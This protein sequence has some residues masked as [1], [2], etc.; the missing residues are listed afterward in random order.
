MKNPIY[1]ARHLRGLSL[2]IMQDGHGVCRLIDPVLEPS[3]ASI[4]V[5]LD[6]DGK[7]SVT[8][9]AE[10]LSVSHVHMQKIFRSMLSAGVV[11]SQVDPND[12]R[13]TFY[14]LTPSGQKLLPKVHIINGA[15]AKVISDL[16]DETGHD[17][18][19][20]LAAFHLALSEKPWG[21]RVSSKLKQRKA[22]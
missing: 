4:L 21:A 13:R 5:H 22:D 6:N 18:S 11:N 7:H 16:Q 9:A 2:H 19:A 12:A 10:K 8:S 17:L 20:A 15:V 14:T 3:W 1:L